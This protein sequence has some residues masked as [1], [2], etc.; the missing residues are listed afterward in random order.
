MHACMSVLRY[1][2]VDVNVFLQYVVMRQRTFPVIIPEAS[3]KQTGIE[4]PKAETQPAHERP[5]PVM[6]LKRPA[7]KRSNEER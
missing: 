1:S 2:C 4:R 7:R 6:G 5:N 3:W